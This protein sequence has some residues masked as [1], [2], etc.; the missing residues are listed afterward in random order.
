[1][2]SVNRKAIFSTLWENASIAEERRSRAGVLSPRALARRLAIIMH[3]MLRNETE[4]A[5]A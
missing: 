3:A 5:P 4:F 1:V 2:L